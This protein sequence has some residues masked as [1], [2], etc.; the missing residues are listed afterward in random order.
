MKL[1]QQAYLVCQHENGIYS[2]DRLSNCTW[3]LKKSYALWPTDNLMPMNYFYVH[4]AHHIFLN[5]N[6]LKQRDMKDFLS[7]PIL[8]QNYL[9][10]KYDRCKILKIQN[11][12]YR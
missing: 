11:L 6:Q 2:R 1:L 7:V 9:N 12:V 10:Q 5:Q 8:P 3:H 4:A